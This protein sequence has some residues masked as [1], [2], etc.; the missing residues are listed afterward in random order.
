MTTSNAYDVIVIGTG[1]AGCEAALAAARIGARTLILSPNLDR[2][3]YMPCN[4]SI[5]GPGKSQ[6]V[7]EVDALGGMMG[8]AAD[9]TAMQVR[10][11]N[12]SKG[13]A[14]RAIRIQCDKTLY[15]LVMKE[16]LEVQPN[17]QLIQDEAVSLILDTSGGSPAVG[18][19]RTRIAGDFFAPTIVVTAGTFLRARMIA[20]ESS[21]SG[22]RAGEGGDTHL[23]TS[24][25][26]LDLQLRRFKT[27]T[28]PRVD[29]RTVDIAQTTPQPGDD[30]PL[31]LSWAG[32]HGE[33]ESLQLPPPKHGPFSIVDRLGGRRQVR[34]YQ[35]A[36]VPAAHDLIRANLH[37]APM[38]NGTIEGSGPRYCPSI[39]DKI[40][41]FA[42]KDSHPVFL[43]P[44][45]WRSHEIY[46]QGLSTSLPP[47]I[48]QGVVNAIPGMQQARITRF[49]YAVEYDAL[50]PTQL[51]R[52]LESH[53]TPGL[54]FA[55]QVNGTSGYEEAA[56]QG[57]VAGANAAARALGRNPLLLTRDNSYI[58]V[59]IDDLISKPFSEPYRML[60]SRAEYRLLLRSDTAHARLAP[61]GH[62]LGLVPQLQLHDVQRHAM[63]IAETIS[64][65]DSIWLGANP[66][67]AASLESHGLQAAS[68]SLTALDLA[69]RPH[70]R[71][72]KVLQAVCE[73][74]MW[75]GPAIETIPM[76]DLAIS[77][78]YSAF[79]EKEEREVARHRANEHRSIPPALEFSAVPG[80]RIE[81]VAQLTSARPPSIGH[82][83]RTA[84]VTPSDIG[85]LLVHLTRIGA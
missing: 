16:T 37:R 48:Q 47:D 29:A 71:P 35:S 17:L 4:P 81:A 51:T 34:C 70:T 28:P 24:L 55:G 31:W 84:G 60:T 77:I 78:Q 36:T 79:I 21:S 65:L 69:R 82:A 25:G 20:G 54:F 38:Y 1:H 66:R 30:R 13:P 27:G 59:M 44:E 43:E 53:T 33:V 10:E 7:A 14:V 40:G 45:G 19:L 12:A 72:E 41:R 63:T 56:G 46:V 58:G 76:D 61:L 42:D 2:V 18:G 83:S 75:S 9:A 11:L 57:L 23:S 62:E 26:A 3:G 5:G 52:T 85:A 68:R 49:G 15:A 80:L 6:I 74:G 8:R 64:N 32:R 50:D 39:E 67:H 73:L 22:G